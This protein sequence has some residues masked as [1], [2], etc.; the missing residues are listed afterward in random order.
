MRADEGLIDQRELTPLDR[1]TKIVLEKA[2]RQVCSFHGRLEQAPRASPA[3]LGVVKREVGMAEH[4]LVVGSGVDRRDADRSRNLHPM[5]A[6]DHRR[7]SGERRLGSRDGRGG[8]RCLPLDDGEFI[9]AQARDEVVGPDQ[10][11]QEPRGEH[12]ELVAGGVPE[13]IVG[14]LEAVEIDEE[15]RGRSIR[16]PGGGNDPFGLALEQ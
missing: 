1:G 13:E 12:Q 8:L 16:S 4:G 2:R 15:E 3:L 7:Q 11:G 5:S 6:G 14:I 9:A 10:L